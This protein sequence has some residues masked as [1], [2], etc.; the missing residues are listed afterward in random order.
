MFSGFCQLMISFIQIKL[1]FMLANIKIVCVGKEADIQG[2]TGFKASESISRGHR[3][4][5]GFPI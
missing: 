1:V 3:C 2:G 5:S 4:H